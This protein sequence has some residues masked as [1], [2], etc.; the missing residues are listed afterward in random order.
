MNGR[1]ENPQTPIR[2]SSQRQKSGSVEML[3]TRLER[4]SLV[5]RALWSLLAEK[6]DLTEEQLINRMNQIDLQ[7]GVADG[8]LKKQADNCPRCGRLISP[9][10]ASCM[11]C[12]SG[13]AV[14]TAFDLV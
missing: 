11:F 13:K 4:L 2:S 6:T 5:C 8:R 1:H 14:S 12:G 7:D 3:E 9:R 10:H